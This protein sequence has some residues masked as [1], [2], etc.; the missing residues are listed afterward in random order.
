MPILELTNLIKDF[1]GLRALDNVNLSVEK[2]EIFGLIGPNGSGK[3]TLLNVITGFLPPTAG[4]VLY[5]G[6]SIAGLKPF[7]IAK[8]KL[9]RTFQIT[10]VFTNLTVEENILHASHLKTNS[11]IWGS[12]F[13]TPGYRR[14]ERQLQ[15]RVTEL[16]AFTGLEDKRNS[17]AANLGAGE[18]RDLE[19]AVALAADPEMMLLDEP[20]AGMTAE[21]QAKLMR[22]IETVRDR[23][24]TVM[25]I[26]HNMKV[27]MGI[28]TRI[29]CLNFGAK[30]AEGSAEEI[31]SNE[32]VISAYLG[33]KRGA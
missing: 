2:G 28:C 19:M 29:M 23:G 14:E 32:A 5:K 22:L 13:T 8:E 1:G 27:I 12:L 9:I 11:T 25:V 10:S 26:E 3:T 4:D 6:Q 17:S 33:G 21:E 7:Q 18:Q 31:A 16:L 24:I 15:E 30:I 20:A